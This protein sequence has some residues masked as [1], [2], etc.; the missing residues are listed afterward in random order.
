[1][2]TFEIQTDSLV[3]SARH[4]VLKTE[5]LL[6]ETARLKSVDV[7]LDKVA[8]AILC[9]EARLPKRGE[10][11][12]WIAKVAE[13][14]FWFDLGEDLV[15]VGYESPVRSEV[16]EDTRFVAYLAD[17]AKLEVAVDLRRAVI[18]K[19]DY[20]KRYRLTPTDGVYFPALNEEQNALVLSDDVNVL[21]QGVAGSGKTNI[22]IDKIIYCAS[23]GYKGKVLYTT[24]SRGL[25]LDTASKVGVWQGDVLAVAEAIEKGKAIFAD[26][27]KQAAVANRLGLYPPADE[28]RD[29]VV[30]LRSVA[31]FL[32]N[33]VEYRLILDL[34]AQLTGKNAKMA[35]EEYFATR[36]AKDSRGRGRLDKLRA[37]GTE[38]V[39]KEIFGLIEGWCDPQDPRRT[40]SKQEYI[41]MRADS[42]G[43]AQCEEIYML[44][45]DY[46]RYAAKD[47]RE[48]NNTLSRALLAMELPT[49]S[50]VIADE[51][52][53]FAEVTLVLLAKLGRKLFCVG[54]ALQMINPSF[55]RFAYLK[56]LLFDAE[57]A[58]VATLR[59]NYRSGVKIQEI[60]DGVGE[61]NAEAFGTHAFV[62]AG[63]AVDDGQTV[64]ATYVKDRSFAEGLAKREQEA[65]LVVPD[66]A[67]KERLRRILPTQE[68]LTVSEI[69]GLE[70]DV[71]VLYHLLDTY[72]REWSTLSRRAISRKTADENSVYRYYFNLFYVGASRARKHLYLVEGQVPD[73]FGRLVATHFAEASGQDALSRLEQ[74]A[75][76]KLDE[77]EQKQRIDQFVKLGQ[78]ANARTAALRL[79][80][81]T[82]EIK[83]IDIHAKLAEDG[84]LR[85]AGIAFWQMGALS[86]AKECFTLSGDE[87]LISLMDAMS[88]Q[89]EGKLDV[90]LLRY[91]PE[92]KDDPKI[93]GLLAEVAKGDLEALRQQRRAVTTAMRQVK[94]G[95]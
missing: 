86:D 30:F 49:Y 38:I 66:R 73:L 4:R 91:L 84:D 58:N 32:Q 76:K 68:I 74:V 25:L 13:H 47:G 80:N 15:F 22:C 67:V 7:M 26:D 50:L 92:L 77:A 52:Q 18:P 43:R 46:R 71:V 48:D 17:H 23:R 88:G 33:N 31:A 81:A 60:L 72:E 82:Y 93:I 2:I 89:G 29:I 62:L 51:V 12:L 41:D 64:S 44:A 40:L 8:G 34:Y 61:L 27:N 37:L 14:T 94:K 78:F 6:R 55:F 45:E 70:R 16:K 56:R 69:K 87:E 42:F 10:G 3:L 24:F 57:T 63:Q 39:Y 5:R 65:T 19:E 95:E 53:D 79:S 28:S 21:A 83:R 20:A 54:D 36:Y 75:G 85:G 35:D 90:H 1:M 9:N 11:E 59:A